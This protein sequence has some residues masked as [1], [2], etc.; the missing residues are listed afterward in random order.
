MVGSVVYLRSMI[1]HIFYSDLLLRIR[2]LE[3]GVD[4]NEL[5]ECSIYRFV[6]SHPYLVG[7]DMKG[8]YFD[9]KEATQDKPYV[10]SSALSKLS[11]LLPGQFCDPRFDDDSMS[12]LLTDLLIG[13]EKAVNQS[14]LSVRY[15]N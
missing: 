14:R 2:S 13:D 8:H 4:D 15:N 12:I 7:V 10:Q 5:M 3:H 6:L 11:M 1:D 9:F